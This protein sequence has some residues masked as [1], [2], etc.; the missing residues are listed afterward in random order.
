[1]TESKGQWAIAFRSDSKPAEN[2]VGPDLKLDVV[3]Q[4]VVYPPGET[5]SF[6]PRPNPLFR[7]SP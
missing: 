5:R 4:P 3:T 2:A 7:A 1:M 6:N